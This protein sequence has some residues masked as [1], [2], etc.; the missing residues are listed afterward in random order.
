MILLGAVP[1]GA[2]ITVRMKKVIA[3]TRP[4]IESPRLMLTAYSFPSGHPSAS[5]LFDGVLAALLG[6][7]IRLWRW[8]ALV[9]MGALC[10][11]A[12]VAFSRLYLGAHFLSDVLAGFAVGVAWL[13]L[14]LTATH[15]FARHQSALN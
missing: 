4:Q 8:R 12:L 2:A 15:T 14:C 3:R 5:T 11:V 9:C 7:R 10:L 13:A 1:G 6:P